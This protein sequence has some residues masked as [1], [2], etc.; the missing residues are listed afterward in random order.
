MNDPI[1]H[2]PIDPDAE[3]STSFDADA[4][5]PDQMRVRLGKRDRMMESGQQRAPYPIV[6]PR[7]MG[8]A[9]V[10]AQYGHLHTGVETDDVLS[11]AGRVVFLRVTGKLC[12]ATLQD[13]DGTRLQLMVSLAEVGEQ[14][15]A[16]FKADVDLGDFISAT[17]RV[18]SSR[19][20]ELSVLAQ[21]WQMAAKAIR[22]LPVLHKGLSE[23]ARVRERY[24]DL[25]VRPAA[26]DMVRTRAA[27]MAS[28]RST[29][30]AEG[31]I[32]VETPMLQT[33]HGG[34][35]ARPFVTR[36][37]AMGIDL[38]LRIAPE[39]FLKRALVGGVERVFEINRN[40]R[41]EGA[42]SSH[43]PE[44]AML[45]FYQAYADYTDVADLTRTI[46]QAA[47]VAMTGTTSVVLH[48]GAE[49]DLGGDWERISLYESLSQ[50]LDEAVTPT[51]ELTRLTDL[52][53]Q[54]GL[55]VD[56]AHRTHGKLVEELW[57]ST[58]KPNLRA[59]VFVCDFPVDTSPL[60]KGHRSCAG[61]A[62][63]WDLY[64]RGVELATGYSELNDPVVQRERFAEQAK[65]AAA[66]DPEAMAVDEDFLRAMEYGMPPAGGVG[67]G[68]DRLL[69]TLTGLGI[70]ETILFPLVRPQ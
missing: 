1:S 5:L 11:V 33:M 41:N 50:A 44:F 15:L 30:H 53:R 70:R 66:G 9:Q 62:E 19:R 54:Y 13:G 21:R 48:D 4:N 34:A 28:I 22:P 46:V 57:E 65:L 59:P 31:F 18:I 23:E 16:D 7:T 8:L 69:M 43:S 39:L 25:M 14:A 38:F 55:P 20:G 61:V 47:A 51:T 37:N 35:S 32:E 40:F 24:A 27:V 29:L 42:D 2:Q 58:V 63:K 68:I 45:E 60:V 56:P 67:M 6:V 17:G 52:A 64:V 26:R 36:S 49:L 12:F 3:V 10:R